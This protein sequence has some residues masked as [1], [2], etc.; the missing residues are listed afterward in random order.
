MIEPKT[1]SPV[2]KEVFETLRRLDA[3][4]LANAIE[5]FHERLRNEGFVDNSIHCLFPGLTP[6]LGYAVTVKIRGSAPPTTN[7]PYGDRTDWWDYL[8][9]VPA[10]RVV[11]VQ[12]IATRPG[13]GS[14][15][16]AVHMN[17]L[18]AL[19]CVGVVTNG[20]VRD[21]PAAQTAGFH[22]FAGSVTVSHAYVHIVEVGAP[23]EVGG[24]K[25]QSG[26]LLH[27]D[28]H[29]V[30]SIPLQIAGRIPA[31]AAQI[32]AKKQELIALC[33]SPDFSLEK[34][35]AAVANETF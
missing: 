10:P 32:A 20:A 12:D 18:R 34:L 17:I 28:L 25:I 33:Q 4:T 5:A 13:L 9:S 2:S 7:G 26:E 30:Q 27:G 24:L 23:V 35:R 19:N 16:G 8:L 15:V 31:V 11:V 22:Y 1:S 14:L 3:C 6:M 21:I 29:G